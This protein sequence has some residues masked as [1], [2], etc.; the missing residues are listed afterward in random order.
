MKIIYHL[1]SPFVARDIECRQQ[2]PKTAARQLEFVEFYLGAL[3]L[4]HQP[5]KKNKRIY[6]LLKTHLWKHKI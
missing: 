2:Q 6:Y 1:C 3:L 5:K 4:A